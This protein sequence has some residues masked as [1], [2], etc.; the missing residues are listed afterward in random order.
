MSNK[1]EI[2]ELDKLK[3]ELE[4]V[5][6]EKDQYLA[7]WQ[8]ARAD[9]LNYIK[10]EQERLKL[11]IEYA[12][13]GLIM[14]LL[15]ILDSFEKA[16][17]AIPQGYADNQIIKGFLQIAEQIKGILKNQGLEELEIGQSFDPATQEIVS[18]EPNPELENDTIIEISLKGY[19]FKG[20]VIRPAKVKIVKN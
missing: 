5:I 6:K 10:D 13:Q 16:E 4:E 15:P 14:E 18:L 12:N 19:A 3:K 11:L 1:K 20:K 17:M 7:G 2:S 9:H 8:R